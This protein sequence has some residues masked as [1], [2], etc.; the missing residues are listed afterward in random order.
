MVIKEGMING[1]IPLVTALEGNLMHLKNGENALLID[2][3]EEE[4][5]VIAQGIDQ[6]KWMVDHQPSIP[7]FSRR[8]Y[9]Y[10]ATTFDKKKFQS[11]YRSFLV[12]NDPS[13]GRLKR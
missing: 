1:C 11:I 9:D 8:A 4:S 7:S 10:A 6:I 13:G 5:L 3:I 12:D 2:A